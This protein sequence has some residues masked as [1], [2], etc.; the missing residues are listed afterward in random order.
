M[1][2]FLNGGSPN[3]SA[4]YAAGFRKYLNETGYVEG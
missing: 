2:G 4:C 1:V 3:A